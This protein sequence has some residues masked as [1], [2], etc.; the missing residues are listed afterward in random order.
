MQYLLDQAQK[1]ATLCP[2]IEMGVYADGD[3]DSVG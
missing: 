1:A 2:W 3:H